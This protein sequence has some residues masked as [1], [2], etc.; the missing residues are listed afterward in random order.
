MDKKSSGKA[1][2]NIAA[3]FL[4]KKGYKILERNFYSKFGEIDIIA[5][6]KD[7]L[8]FVEVRSKSYSSFGNPEETVNIFKVKKILK[9]A[10]FY[11][12]K[13]NPDFKEIRFDIISFLH[14]NISHIKNA[15]DMDFE[16]G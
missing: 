8:V 2:E 14:N 12:L 16:W 15:F 7:T 11:I 13:K 1:A 5:K 9:T 6:D 10:Q 4:E 3:S